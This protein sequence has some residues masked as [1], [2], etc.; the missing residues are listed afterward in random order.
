M[1]YDSGYA[2]ACCSTLLVEASAY[3]LKHAVRSRTRIID[4]LRLRFRLE[5][6]FFRSIFIKL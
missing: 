2:G 3:G 6:D 4:A 5:S 1:S